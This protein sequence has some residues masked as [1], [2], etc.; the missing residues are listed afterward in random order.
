MKEDAGEIKDLFESNSH[1]EKS[2]PTFGKYPFSEYEGLVAQD[3]TN[4]QECPGPKFY[5]RKISYEGAA[6]GYLQFELD[7]PEKGQCWLPMLVLKP[8]N[9]SSGLGRE[10][11]SS[12]LEKISELGNYVGIGLNVYSENPK[13]LRF[14]YKNGFD[15]IIGV[16]HETSNDKNYTCITLWRGIHA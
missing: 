10:A 9:Q 1:L 12:L 4:N 13:A 15:K 3:V 8:N 16:D 5:L 2:D 14:W 6:I 11:V 7:A